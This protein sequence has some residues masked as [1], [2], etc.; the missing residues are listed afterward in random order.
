MLGLEIRLLPDQTFFIQLGVF[1]TV[2]IGLNYLIFKPVLRILRYRFE[3]TVGD[4][5]K[6]EE[7]TQ[8]THLLMTEYETKIADARAKAHELKEAIRQEGVDQATQLV[9]EA[10][11]LRQKELEKVRQEVAKAYGMAEGQLVTQ[12]KTL[13][14]EIAEKVLGHGH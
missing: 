13:G 8:K 4:R 6:I 5:K 2:L 14:R 9:H 3:K 7:L 1:L 11:A 12:A 10:K